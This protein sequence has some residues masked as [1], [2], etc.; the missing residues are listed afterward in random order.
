M[1][2]EAAAF[3]YAKLVISDLRSYSSDIVLI[4]QGVV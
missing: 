2:V 3:R 4:V 1:P